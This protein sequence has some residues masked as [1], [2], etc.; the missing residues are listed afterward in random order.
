[1][2]SHALPKFTLYETQLGFHWE[3]EGWV[4]GREGWVEGEGGRGGWEEGGRVRELGVG[5]REGEKDVV[6]GLHCEVYTE[7]GGGKE[8][9]I[10]SFR[11]LEPSSDKQSYPELQY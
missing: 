5:G 1:V 11:I 8:Q 4:G 7:V 10:H 2:L 6:G 3:K 9:L